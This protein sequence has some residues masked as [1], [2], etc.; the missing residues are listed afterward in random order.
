MNKFYRL[1]ELDIDGVFKTMLLLKK[2]KLVRDVTSA[3]RCMCSVR[4]EKTMNLAVVGKLCVDCCSVFAPCVCEHACV[5]VCVC[6]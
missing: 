5:C 2:K 4:D 6:V 3:C 1:V